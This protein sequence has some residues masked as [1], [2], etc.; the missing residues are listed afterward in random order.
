MVESDSPMNESWTP[1][2]K[3]IAFIRYMMCM[4][5]VG[6]V[7]GYQNLPL[8]L[9]KLD[10]KTLAVMMDGGDD[11]H[12]VPGIHGKIHQQVER[13]KLSIEAA[14]YRFKDIRPPRACGCKGQDF[15][16]VCR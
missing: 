15:C 4:L 3:D 6:G 12:W 5:N 8:A 16:P 9:Q 1:G 7:W 11:F 13:C 14:G 10:E 2:P